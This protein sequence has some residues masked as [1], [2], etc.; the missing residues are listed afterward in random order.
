MSERFRNLVDLAF[1]MRANVQLGNLIQ[2]RHLVPKCLTGIKR[3]E[4][5]E[6][7]LWLTECLEDFYSKACSQLPN[8]EVSEYE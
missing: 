3:A 2:A 1:V 6:M 5:A 7:K 4:F 8:V